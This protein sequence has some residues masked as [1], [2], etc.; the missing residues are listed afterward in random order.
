[1]RGRDERQRES[2]RLEN[3][4]REG[5]HKKKDSRATIAPRHEIDP[6]ANEA[7]AKLDRNSTEEL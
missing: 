3:N 7:Q 4:A 1:M 2:E 6:M 5:G